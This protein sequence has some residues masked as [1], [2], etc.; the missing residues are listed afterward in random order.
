MLSVTLIQNLRRL[1]PAIMI[2]A[3]L[4]VLLAGC[5][6]QPT[7]RGIIISN[8]YETVN[9]ET[10]GRYKANFHTHTTGSD[11]RITPHEVVDRYRQQGHS[12]LA[13][14]DHNRVTWPW[15]AFSSLQPSSLSRNVFDT[16]DLESADLNYQDRDPAALG[17]LAV[18][19]NELSS[20]HHTGSFFTDH[21]GT[22]TEEASLEAIGRKGGMAMLYHP[23]RYDETIEWY[24]DL[25]RRFP[26]L[27][28]LEVFNQGNKYPGDRQKWDRILMQLL[29]ERIVWGYSND[30]M[31]YGNHLGRNWSIMFM[32]QLSEQA[33]RTAFAN[34]T[35]YFVYSPH[36]EQPPLPPVIN[37]IN[38][39]HDRGII[40]ID[41]DNYESIEWISD[42]RIIHHGAQL[43]LAD[44]NRQLGRYV[45]AMLR[46]RGNSVAG[47]QPFA[48][49]RP[50]KA[51]ISIL[52][53]EGRATYAD[54][55]HILAAVTIT[56]TWDGPVDVVAEALLD[57]SRMARRSFNIPVG[58]SVKMDVPVRLAAI[59][60]DKTL[61]IRIDMGAKYGGFRYL[62]LPLP[63]EIPLPVDIS[64]YVPA[65]DRAV[66]VVNNLNAA[67][68]IT[69]DLAVTDATAI[70]TT[71]R[72]CESIMVTRQVTIEPQ[73][74]AKVDYPLSPQ[75]V[76][77]DVK[78]FIRASWDRS[79]GLPIASFSSV[80]NLAGLK[81]M[82]TA[83]PAEP[84]ADLQTAEDVFPA[85]A[86][87]NWGGTADLSG[88]VSWWQ[89]GDDLVIA[90][91]IRDDQQI[92]I[93]SGANIWNGDAMQLGVYPPGGTLTNIAL[94]LT[95][96][97]VQFNPFSGPD[98]ELAEKAKYDVVRS[99]DDSTTSYL[100][101]M[102][103][104]SLGLERRNGTIFGLNVVF[105]DDD[106][107]RGQ[108]KWL[109]MAPG[110]AGGR[111]PLLF[112][113]FVIAEQ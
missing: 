38:V 4:A 40:S 65:T 34:G 86:R 59:N 78:M 13:I 25:Y 71:Q 89:D 76:G 70:R 69:V 87:K 93:R 18:Q 35:S 36:R 94:A 28:G 9:W 110:L 1:A 47:T 100:L 66:I 61:E 92:N 98:P 30:D 16:G 51:S 102:P 37:T 81:D 107:G 12:I 83:R 21:N 50:V 91:R 2:A 79:F 63:L 49:G 84:Q 104:E 20:H 43:K 48:L 108:Q 14:T 62:H 85:G 29:P 31:H 22:S 67:H 73:G 112:P 113:R 32:P 99:N 96:S 19:G 44:H 41:A 109:Q 3:I 7:E 103:L 10:T 60:Q 68:P 75:F 105:F 80:I 24:V 15:T 111:D 33:L 90:A 58:E 106:N 11:G 95:D 27:F 54:D 88:A 17:M 101:R 42:G 64:T 55:N 8:P 72:T 23:G 45:R 57:K 56:N 26:H 39:D 53:S 97:G 5:A 77:R 6:Q 74:Q 82:P 52:D 46:G